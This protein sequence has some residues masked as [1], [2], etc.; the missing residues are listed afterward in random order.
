MSPINS[1]TV[2]YQLMLPTTLIVHPLSG[3]LTAGPKVQYS[4]NGVSRLH[5]DYQPAY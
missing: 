4:V 5:A 1:Q 2:S 3:K